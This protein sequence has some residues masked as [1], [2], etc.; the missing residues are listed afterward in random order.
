MNNQVQKVLLI[1][2]CKYLAFKERVQQ[3]VQETET[4]DISEIDS[5]GEDAQSSQT[6][7]NFR[8]I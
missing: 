3:C 6:L 4:L 8:S 2:L 1:T 5:R 7:G